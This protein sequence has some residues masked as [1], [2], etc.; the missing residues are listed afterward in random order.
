[1]GFCYELNGLFAELLAAL[2]YDVDLLA[3][4][5][6]TGDTY[7]PPFDHLALRVV[8]AGEPWLVDVGFGAFV[9][10]PLRFDEAGEQIDPAGTYR[11]ERLANGD[12]VVV[13]SDQ[14]VYRLEPRPRELAEFVPT[15]WWQQTSPDSHFTHGPIC[16]ILTADGRVTVRG[17]TLIETKSGAR[18]E[19][20][21]DRGRR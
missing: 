10:H 11:L 14:P 13:E 15:C 5:V 8:A 3:A 18:N 17:R 19:R 20:D 1:V 2:G 12:I 16:S 21:V 4:S 6:A 9:H 7:G